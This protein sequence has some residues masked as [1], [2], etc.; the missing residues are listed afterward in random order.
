M[1]RRLRERDTLNMDSAEEKKKDEKSEGQGE[2]DED[3]EGRENRERL[4][5]YRCAA[6]SSRSCRQGSVTTAQFV[7]SA[8]GMVWGWL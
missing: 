8:Y 5:D 2:T 3:I 1:R 7:H 6:T 4:R